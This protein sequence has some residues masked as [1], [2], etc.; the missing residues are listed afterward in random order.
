MHSAYVGRLFKL[1]M[2]AALVLAVV[3][4][5]LVGGRGNRALAQDMQPQTFMVQAGG[6]G[7]ANTELVGYAPS[8]LK[9]HRGDT[10][11]WHFNSF[12]NVHLAE[13][14]TDFVIAPTVDGKPLPQLN[15]AVAFPTIQSGDTYSGGD[16][17]T[18]IVILDPAAPAAFSLVMDVEPGVYVY[19]CDVHPGMTGTIEVVADDEAIP[20][21][22]EA[23]AA[24]ADEMGAE[25]GQAIGAMMEMNQSAPNTS[26]DGT[27]AITAG[28][29]GG[30]RASAQA[31]FSPLVVIH[32][33]ESVTWTIPADSAEPHTVT[34]ANFEGAD[35]V[36]MEQ[37]NGPP[38]FALGPLFVPDVKTEVTAAD[39]FNS[40]FLLPG[41]SYT[42]KFTEAGVYAYSCRLH[43]GMIGVVIAEP[44]M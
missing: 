27:V 44:P 20:S 28:S 37:P 14:L 11:M 33:G 29:G 30:G 25:L 9:I 2:V 17:N 19:F 34:S 23:A 21:P 42:L 13:G 41:Q 40:G 16:A 36:P 38:V 4:A 24:G 10:V 32:A 26:A 39:S 31:F 5:G 6:Y 43:T 22:I 12:H 35:F 1:G 18:G 7:L 8:S 15:P 3:A